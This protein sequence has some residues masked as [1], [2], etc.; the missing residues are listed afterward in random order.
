MDF[1]TEKEQKV[2]KGNVASGL[3]DGTIFGL[4]WGALYGPATLY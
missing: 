1:L 3:F 4:C 2:L